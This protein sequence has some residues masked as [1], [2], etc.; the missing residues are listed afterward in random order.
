MTELSATLRPRTPFTSSER[1]SHTAR[2][3][4][5]SQLQVT[6]DGLA[7][8]H[9]FTKEATFTATFG[10]RLDLYL[11]VLLADVYANRWYALRLE[12]VTLGMTAAVAGLVVGLSG[13]LDPELAGLALLYASTLTGL[14]EYTTRLSSEAEARFTSIERISRHIENVPPEEAVLPGKAYKVMEDWPQVRR[15]C[16][17]VGLERRGERESARAQLA[18][19]GCERERAHAAGSRWL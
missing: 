15:R 17:A 12:L 11:R 1:L 8:V 7:T 18:A 2:S 10:R 4:L 3:P 19:G 5:V 14:F 16:G 9:A 6:V 13:T